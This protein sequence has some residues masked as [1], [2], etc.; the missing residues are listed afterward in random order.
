MKTLNYFSK[1]KLAEKPHWNNLRKKNWSKKAK[2]EVN[3]LNRQKN[4]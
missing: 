2:Q 1:T 3:N 4:A